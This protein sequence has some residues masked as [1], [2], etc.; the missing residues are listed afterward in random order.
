MRAC[1]Y[2]ISMSDPEVV[3][4]PPAK[5]WNWRRVR[6]Y[7]LQLVLLLVIIGGVRIWQQR[8]LVSGPAPAR[9]GVLLD[10]R[11]V[12]ATAQ[13]GQ[14]LLVHFWASWCPVC[15]LEQGSIESL[16]RS[17]PTLT[18]AMQSGSD[19]EVAAHMRKEVLSFPVLN[20]PQGT[21]S[22]EWGVRAVPTSFIVDAQGRI[23]FVEVGYTT[24]IGLRLR[25]WWAGLIAE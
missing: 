5:R 8:D 19:A 12:A 7:L 9:T 1:E 23:R 21:I 25:L 22:R 16:A 24:G 10:G 20:D 6:G 2:T 13:A 17:Y 4:G 14:P 18:V 15:K 3:P 11:A